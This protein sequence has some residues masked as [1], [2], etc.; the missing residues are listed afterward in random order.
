M[1]HKEVPCLYC[2]VFEAAFKSDFIEGQTQTYKLEDI[3]VDAFQYVVYWFYSQKLKTC[4]VSPAEIQISVADLANQLSIEIVDD[5]GIKATTMSYSRI[6]EII[7]ERYWSLC[8]VWVLAD[9]LQIPRLQNLVIDELNRMRDEWSIV[10]SSIV[11]LVY[12]TNQLAVPKGA[13]LREFVLQTIRKFAHSRLMEKFPE[14]F[15]Q[16][17]LLELVI[18]Y[19]RTAM[20]PDPFEDRAEFK[21][22][23]HVSED[24]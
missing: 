14:F 1:V 24:S 23:F 16:E 12:D 21:K 13:A 15:P 17:M 18:A 19:K 3:T 2:P 11:N 10:C 7:K 5:G 4:V 8:R 9:R 20:R 22:R 6:I